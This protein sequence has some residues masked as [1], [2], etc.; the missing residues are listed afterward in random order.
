MLNS[1]KYT[2]YSLLLICTP[3][4]I[5]AKNLDTT[6]N[7]RF[8]VG[9]S[10][11][12]LDFSLNKKT[13]SSHRDI[14][15]ATFNDIRLNVAINNKISMFPSILYS[16]R[17]YIMKRVDIVTHDQ[18]LAFGIGIS[19]KMK[20]FKQTGIQYSF[21]LFTYNS[22]R[23]EKT[24]AGKN[25]K[26]YKNEISSADIVFTTKFSH[27]LKLNYGLALYYSPE[28]DSFGFFTNGATTKIRIGLI[29]N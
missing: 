19:Y 17:S 14:F 24:A 9:C 5:I 15:F 11:S 8:S 29:Y 21:S 25:V 7:H 12:Q 1:L 16:N 27:R 13:N 23:S 4:F 28:F 10:L 18:L 20:L 26:H 6:E 3:K 22:K 2:C